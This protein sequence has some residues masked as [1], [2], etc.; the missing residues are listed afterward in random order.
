[1]TLSGQDRKPV[2]CGH[3]WS[4]AYDHYP[5]CP[6]APGTYPGHYCPIYGGWSVTCAARS[7][8]ERIAQG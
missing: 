2:A 5:E 7:C 4:Y 8:G 3:C 6:A 1:M